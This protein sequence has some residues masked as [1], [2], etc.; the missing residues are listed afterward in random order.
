MRQHSFSIFIFCL[1]LAL[2]SFAQENGENYHIKIPEFTDPPKIDGK[3]EN[4]I[5]EK[6]AVLSSFTQYEP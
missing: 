1:L 6:G 3:L 5:W 2:T 4:P